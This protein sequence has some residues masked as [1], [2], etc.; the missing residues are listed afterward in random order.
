MGVCVAGEMSLAPAS[1]SLAA[2]FS[3]A[4]AVAVRRSREARRWHLLCA[5]ASE[6]GSLPPLRAAWPG[7]MIQRGTC[8]LGRG[9]S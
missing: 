1:P 2:P 4:P 3:A 6:S 9:F 8:P 7:G 5:V